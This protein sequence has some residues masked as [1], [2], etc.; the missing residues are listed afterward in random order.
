MRATH[1]KLEEEG[2]LLAAMTGKP[3]TTW[4]Y[5]AEL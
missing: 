4:A 1:A 2:A 5:R 3:V